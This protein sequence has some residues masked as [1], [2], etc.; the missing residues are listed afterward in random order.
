[1]TKRR[2]D[3]GWNLLVIIFVYI[4][5]YIYIDIDWARMCKQMCGERDIYIY[6]VYIYIHDLTQEQQ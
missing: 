1:M 6:Y 2:F 4:C 3:L 5:I